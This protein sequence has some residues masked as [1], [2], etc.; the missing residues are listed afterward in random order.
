MD[1]LK[2][3]NLEFRCEPCNKTRRKSM[4]LEYAE[5]GLT[6]ETVMNTLKEMQEVQKNNAADFNKVYEALH[7][8]LQENTGTLRGGME[9]IEEYVKEID[10][11]KRENAA[12]KS[13]VVNLEQ[14]VEDLENY[15]RRNCLEIHGIPEGR[16]ER[17][18]DVVKEVGK[19]LNMNID[20]G[21]ID[22]CHRIGRKGSEKDRPRGIIVKFVRRTDRDAL[23][24]KR[25]ERKKDFST[26]HLGLNTDI[27]IFV[28]DSLSP[29]RRRLFALARQQKKDKGYKY[30]WLR[31]GNI[32]MR[33]H[34]GGEII[35]IRT[36]AD[37]SNL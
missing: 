37:L 4:R 28:N 23:M 6:L 24:N 27:P 2:E 7:T 31:N 12:L 20:E 1:Y 14:R 32:L 29:S 19:A 16:G 25:R 9:R 13:K 3:Q 17:V 5:G 33:Q 35:E 15:S 21:M 18:S 22:A 26:R 30:L 36:Q 34:D 10:E 8:G 11:L